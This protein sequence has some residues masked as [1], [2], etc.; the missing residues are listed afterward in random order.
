MNGEALDRAESALVR[1]R[2]TRLLFRRAEIEQL[3]ADGMFVVDIQPTNDEPF[4][5][6]M[7]RAEF[8]SEFSNVLRT[9]SWKDGVYHCPVFP[10]RGRKY[11]VS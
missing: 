10:E 9:R 3:A 2:A 1:Y 7:T 4:S 6:A 5:V 11:I 8:E